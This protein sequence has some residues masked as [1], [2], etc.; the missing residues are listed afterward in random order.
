[1]ISITR[2][3]QS[4]TR[5][6]DTL[7]KSIITT[8]DYKKMMMTKGSIDSMD[9]SV[10][11]TDTS[12]GGY[13]LHT[14]QQKPN[15]QKSK[16]STTESESTPVKKGSPQYVTKLPQSPHFDPNPYNKGFE[17]SYRNEGFRDNSTFPTRNNSYGTNI[18][19]DTPIVHQTD[20]EDSGSDYYGNSSTLPIRTRDN[21]SFLTELKQHL[22]PEYEQLN[23]AHSSF[24][25]S[26]ASSNPP[27]DNSPSSIKSYASDRQN[28]TA[29]AAA[30]SEP[31]KQSL[32]R[33]EQASQPEIR[34]INEY[35]QPTTKFPPEPDP[36]R[37]ASYYT[38]MRDARDSQ[39]VAQMIL[40]PPVVSSR[41]KT[42][43]QSSA[44]YDRP[45]NMRSK[46]EALLEEP[47]EALAPQLKSDSRSYSQPMETA[48]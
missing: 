25:P 30:A 35:A 14:I 9:K 1:M 27:Y 5:S 47:S 18:N 23:S 31:L 4:M 19:D 34:K 46:S 37:P 48:M 44:V 33:K 38:A 2:N 20:A 28:I 22:P 40:P 6:N 15:G 11:S 41:P 7:T 45:V 21:L 42:L 43:Y 36:R 13:D 39:T 3:A 32:P 29:I 10:I 26:G 24:M 12:I 8:P 16:F 17:L